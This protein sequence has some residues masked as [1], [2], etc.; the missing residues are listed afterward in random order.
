MHKLFLK[1][2][3][4]LLALFITS[5]SNKEESSAGVTSATSQIKFTLTTTKGKKINIEKYDIM[6]LSKELEG[7][8]VL[9]NFW[10]PWCAPCVKE[11]P[12]FV[13]LQNKYKDDFIILGILFDKKSSKK[14][15]LDFIK[16]HKI[17]FPIAIGDENF[18][19]AKAFEDVQM[20]PES[21]LYGKD[22][23]FIEKFI[24]EVNQDR[25]EKYI[26]K[27]MNN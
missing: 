16:K 6:I 20:V 11:M 24:G 7:K 12:V 10:A 26:K 2:I 27:S 18:N 8:V 17:N 1:V 3:L 9:I 5:C 13:D 23:V 19:I 21:Y 14:E 25:L 15:I 4:V 22:G